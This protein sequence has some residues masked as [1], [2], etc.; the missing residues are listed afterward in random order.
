M[1]HSATV[2]GILTRLFQLL[3]DSGCVPDQWRESTIIPITP[4]TPSKELKDYRPVA[5]TSVLG[6]FMEREVCKVLSRMVSDK[7]DPHQFA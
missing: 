4:K 1:L 3:L 2:S 6:K 5:P 7:L